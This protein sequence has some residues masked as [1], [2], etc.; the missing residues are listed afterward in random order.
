MTIKF[1]KNELKRYRQSLPN[2]C[3]IQQDGCTGEANDAHHLFYGSFGADKDDRWQVSACRVCHKWCHDNKH[4]S[5]EK[6]QE[7]AAQNW[8]SYDN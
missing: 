2:Y 6:Y 8:N 7:V 3:Q 5:Q 4:E 1:S